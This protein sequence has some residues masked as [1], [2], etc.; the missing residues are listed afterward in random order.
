MQTRFIVVA[1]YAALL[2]GPRAY[3]AEEQK[4]PTPAPGQATT[5]QQSRTGQAQTGTDTK[6]DPSVQPTEAERQAGGAIGRQPGAT[7][8]VVGTVEKVEEGKL[9]LKTGTETQELK[10]DKSTK[11]TSAEPPFSRDQLAEGAEVRASFLGDSMRATEV[12]VMSKGAASPA[13]A[14]GST[15]SQMGQ[16]PSGTASPS[17]E[18]TGTKQSPSDKPTP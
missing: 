12:H 14:P 5:S 18:P 6:P 1:T 9:T 15:G 11:F 8:S 3:A 7:K 16:P 17:G 10:I 13:G 2:L 4:T